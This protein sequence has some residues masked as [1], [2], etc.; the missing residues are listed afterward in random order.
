MS[1]MKARLEDLG[2]VGREVYVQDFDQKVVS[3]AEAVRA[4][5]E[6]GVG[7]GGAHEHL[8]SDGC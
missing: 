8:Q 4:E 3:E 2:Q 5:D 6:R 7:F 1:W